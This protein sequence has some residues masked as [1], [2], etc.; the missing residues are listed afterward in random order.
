MDLAHPLFFA[1]M[2]VHET[3]QRN[4]RSVLYNPVHEVTEIHQITQGLTNW[5][6]KL[7]GK[8]LGRILKDL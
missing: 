7:V 2:K 1:I 3:K 4:R 6:S 5:L 8:A